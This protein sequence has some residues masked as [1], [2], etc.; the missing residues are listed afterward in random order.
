MNYNNPTNEDIL[1]YLEKLQ[2]KVDDIKDQEFSTRLAKQLG[3]YEGGVN[4][5]ITLLKTA[6]G[7][8]EVV[9]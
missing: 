2:K 5:L 4:F 9:A 3:N 7:K 8:S 1:T 6:T